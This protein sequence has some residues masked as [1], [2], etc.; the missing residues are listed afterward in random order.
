MAC[1]SETLSVQCQGGAD[2]EVAAD[3]E[4]IYCCIYIFQ[5]MGE[6]GDIPGADLDGTTY[7]AEGSLVRNTYAVYNGDGELVLEA[8]QNLDRISFLDADG[9]QV[10]TVRDGRTDDDHFLV[11][12]DGDTPVVILEEDFRPLQRDWKVRGRSERVLATI[13]SDRTV[14][15]FVRLYVPFGVVVPPT[16]AITDADGTPLGRL[17]GRFGLTDDAHLELEPRDDLPQQSLVAAAVAVT[18]LDEW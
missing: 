7:T 4:D 14:A 16:Y 18:V 15:G 17:A 1:G 8:R 6:T 13:E 2:W 10:F 11:P 9:D 12:A 5:R 3:G